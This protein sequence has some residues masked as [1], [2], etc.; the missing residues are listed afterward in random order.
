MGVGDGGRQFCV[1]AAA[2]AVNAK[3]DQFTL[4]Q[5]CE[6]QR[7]LGNSPSP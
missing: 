4:N 2:T 5:T 7:K 3:T 1:L 6:L